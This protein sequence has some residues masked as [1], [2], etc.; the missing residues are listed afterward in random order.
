MHQDHLG[1]R[2]FT[3]M[4]LSLLSLVEFISSVMGPV[5]HC[6]VQEECGFIGA[7]SSVSHKDV[8]ETEAAFMRGPL[9]EVGLFSL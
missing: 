6:P 8:L 4:V 7:I 2:G 9:G 3:Q 5:L 1:A